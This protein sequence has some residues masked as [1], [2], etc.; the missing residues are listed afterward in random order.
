M[1][2]SEMKP[3]S[4]CMEFAQLLDCTAEVFN[5]V[6]L[7]SR[8]RSNIHPTLFGRPANSAMFLPQIYSYEDIDAE[9]RALCLGE[10]VILEEEINPYMR[11]LQD[12]GITVTA[13][14]NHWL[15]DS[16][17]LMYMHF[18][19]L[20]QPLEFARKVQDANMVLITEAVYSD[21]SDH[22]EYPPVANTNYEIPGL[23]NEFSAV[24]N[25]RTHTSNM[26]TCV[27]MK[28]RNNI[29]S[30]ILGRPGKS[31]LVNTE[32][33]A[34]ESMTEDGKALCSGEIVLLQNEINP[35]VKK[36]QA[37]GIVMTGVHNHWLFDNPQLMYIHFVLVDYPVSFAEK[38]RDA[39]SVLTTK[40]VLPTK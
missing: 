7:V 4:L 5:G 25:G 32:M 27:V 3:S 11:K 33:Y 8:L 30:T 21:P 12:H 9:G 40:E 28:V 24:L 22:V 2:N 38:V 29:E 20:D 13:V 34:Y 1:E 19:S 35:F 10:I 17:R 16:P 39:L 15:F 36:L 37:H 18:Q 26:G 31:F 14:H 6:C 23:C